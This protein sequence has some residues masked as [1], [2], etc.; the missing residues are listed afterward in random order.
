MWAEHNKDEKCGKMLEEGMTDEQ[1][2]GLMKHCSNAMN[3]AGK[4]DM[5]PLCH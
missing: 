4:P 3:A 5:M 2:D 1:C